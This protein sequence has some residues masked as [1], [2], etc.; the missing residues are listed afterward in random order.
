MKNIDLTL[1]SENNQELSDYL[2]KEYQIETDKEIVKNVA[3]EL[4]NLE[5]RYSNNIL[6]GMSSR[7]MGS[8]YV[9]APYIPM[10][11]QEQEIFTFFDEGEFLVTIFWD[12]DGTP[13][14]FGQR[15]FF[16]S[17]KSENTDIHFRRIKLFWNSK[18]E[19]HSFYVPLKSSN[20]SSSINEELLAMKEMNPDLDLFKNLK[21]VK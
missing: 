7:G 16:H 10:Y 9:Y 19:S 14:H 8:G 1:K 15:I 5:E 20:L 12:K 21:K 2:A 4:N 17:E 3:S 13:Y 11:I 18:N 6:I